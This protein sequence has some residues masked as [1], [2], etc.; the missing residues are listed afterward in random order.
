MRLNRHVTRYAMMLL[1]AAMLSAAAATDALAR[2]GAGFGHIGGMHGA[3]MRGGFSSPLLDQ[4]PSMP[5]PTFNPSERYTVP[6]SPET[7]VSPASLGS[8]FGNG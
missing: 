6:Q 1:A 4:A 5:R 3:H 8:V 2:G 7:P